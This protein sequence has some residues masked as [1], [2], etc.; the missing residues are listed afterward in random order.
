MDQKPTDEQQLVIDCPTNCVVI[1]K[2]GTGKTFTLAYKIQKILVELPYY[3]GVI[4]ISFTNKASD[5]LEFR[6]LLSGINCKNSFFG[7][8]DKFFLS[9]IIL[10]FG[11]RVFGKAQKEFEIVT[12]DSLSEELKKLYKKGKSD[13]ENL[14]FYQVLFQNGLVPLEKFGFLAIYIFRESWACRRYLKSRFCHIIVDEYQDCDKE[15][16]NLFL[17]L[18]K[19]GLIGIAVGDIDQSIFAFAGKSSDYLI[20]LAGNSKNFHTFA[21][22]INHRSHLSIINYATRVISKNYTP[23][24]VNEIHVFEKCIEG[25]EIQIAEWISAIVPRLLSKY[26][27]NENKVG[28]LFSSR[29]SG[30][31]IHNNLTIPSKA[32]ITTPLDTDPSLWGSIFRNTLYWIFDKEITKFDFVE[33]Y[34]NLNFQQKTVKNI[35]SLLQNIEKSYSSSNDLVKKADLFISIAQSIYPNGLNSLAISNL[36]KVITDQVLLSSYLPAK[37]NEIQLLT[38]HKAKGLEF[39]IVIHLDLYRWVL[40]RYKDDYIQNLNLHYVGVTR[41]K[42]CCILC[43]STLRHNRYGE[44]VEAE[45]SEFLT[46]NDLNT[47][48]EIFEA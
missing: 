36:N 1:A 28:V 32:L 22:S 21:L 6:S 13:L 26:E 10:P 20:E 41:A 42:R 37:E 35:L 43:T 17:S 14:D 39:D 23:L 38:L 11:E 33:K 12:F 27:I 7:T 16:H 44:I 29:R 8:I 9:E 24:L 30:T 31:V 47:L 25:S 5:E 2:P 18:V 3:K 46:M 40:P 34:L 45:K 4:A 15:Q 19:L 48:R